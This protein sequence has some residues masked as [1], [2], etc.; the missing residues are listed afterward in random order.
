MTRIVC[1]LAPYLHLAWLDADVVVLDVLNDRYLLLVDGAGALS[2]ETPGAVGCADEATRAV[3]ADAGFLS[4]RPQAPRLP[5]PSA[6]RALEPTARPT[7]PRLQQTTAFVDGL[8]A[9]AAF[10]RRGF[11]ALIEVARARRPR[12][13]LRPGDP[14][15]ALESFHAIYPWLPWEGDCLQRA[16]LLH[17]HLHRRGHACRWVFGVRTWPF[18]A[19]CWVQIDDLV[20]GDSLSRIG[21]FTPIL[22]V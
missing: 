18:L 8:L 4:D 16:F 2:P 7:A 10:K 17:H 11:A 19:H 13:R 21:G 12:R 14:A 15:L 1:P 3:L 20:V 6:S 5:P 22:A 9:T